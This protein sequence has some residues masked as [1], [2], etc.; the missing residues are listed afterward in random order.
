MMSDFLRK[1][2]TIVSK[3]D[4]F[5]LFYLFLFTIVIAVVETAGVSIIMPYISLANDFS[6][7][8]SNVYY[9]YVYE[10]FEFSSYVRFSIFLGIVIIVF[11]VFRA[12]INALYI[13]KIVSFTQVSYYKIVNKLF[14]NY[15]N[16]PYKNFIGKNSSS[17]T[18]IIISESSYITDIFR[19]FL[20]LLSEILIL[21]FI[22]SM[23]LY[24]NYQIA[25]AITFIL[26]FV[27][28]FLIKTI[29]KVV[30]R[31]GVEREKFQNIFYEM[32]NRNFNNIKM[33]KL[34]N[35]QKALDEFDYISSKYTD[36][37]KISGSIQQFPRLIFEAVGFS[38]VI[39]IVIFILYKNNS[40]ISSSFGLLT[41]FVLGL[42]RILPSITR[43]MASF[44]QILAYYKSIDLI[45]EDM[46]IYT[47][48]IGSD[49]IVFLKKIK[50]KNISF[51][52]IKSENIIENLDLIIEKNDKI[53][54]IGESGSGKSTLVDIIMGLHQVN[55]GNIYID[56]EKLTEKNLT[57]WRGHFGYIPQS[58][59][60]FDGTVGENVAFGVDIDEQK[61]IEALKKAN[62]WKFLETKNGLDTKV[63]ESGVMLSGGQKQRIAIAR[64]LYKNPDV[65][66]LDEAT[67]AL[68][69][70]TEAKIMDEIYEVAKD[71][72]L[73]IIAHRLSTIRRCEKVYKIENGEIKDV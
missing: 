1:L 64:A 2:N 61:A 22:Y 16:M 42:Y 32:L 40:D 51:G 67:S 56:K 50:L 72:T 26:L 3:S 37:Y 23:L 28:L 10:M 65:L 11:Y 21:V 45:H 15:L 69:D 41:I 30:K 52:Y 7:I 19:A 39:L 18:K 34:Q 4:K 60:L 13:Y 48:Q 35:T 44:N 53:A 20:I 25:L 6:L 27:G 43:I 17:L 38:V 71:K 66:V 70:E 73:I 33:L 57:D 59:Y 36:T 55:G 49:K 62:I 29:S 8:E 46:H 63:G 5:T 31:K 68:D 54:F 24:I 12:S 9:K 58:V 47:E 14:S